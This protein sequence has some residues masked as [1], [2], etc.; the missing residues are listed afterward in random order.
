M[1]VTLVFQ[2]P[3]SNHARVFYKIAIFKGFAKFTG[4]HLQPESYL[5]KIAR[6]EPTTLL[7]KR[8]QPWRYNTPTQDLSR[9]FCKIRENIFF[10]RTLPGVANFAKSTGEV[11]C[12][13]SLLQSPVTDTFWEIKKL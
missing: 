10:S 4:D 5:N 7:N 9:G 2:F 12:C 3:K 8:L 13:L 11:L 6:L 1:G